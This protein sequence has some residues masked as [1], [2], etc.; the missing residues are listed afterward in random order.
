VE[1][2][3]YLSAHNLQILV[4]NYGNT[5]AHGVRVWKNDMESEPTEEFAFEDQSPDGISGEQML[6]PKEVWRIRAGTQHRKEFPW[7]IYGH[8]D[9]R[10]IYARKWRTTS[11]YMQDPSV[12][13]FVP[14]RRHNSEE[15]LG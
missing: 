7:F 15:Q 8:I 10:D 12:D 6:Q 11:C 9:Y 4:R 3:Q 14:Y 13:S 2:I 1:S 5:P